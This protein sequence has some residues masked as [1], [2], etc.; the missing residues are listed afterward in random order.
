MQFLKYALAAFSIGSAMAAPAVEP[1]ARD[2]AVGGIVGTVTSLANIQ[3][4]VGTVA[5]V[6]VSVLNEVDSLSE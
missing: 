1:V 5:D 6:K 4:L 3:V 2:N